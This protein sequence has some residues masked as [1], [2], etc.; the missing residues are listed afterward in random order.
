MPDP[1]T[2]VTDGRPRVAGPA[3]PV[4]VDDSAPA[5]AGPA[6]PVVV[7]TSGPVSAGAPLRVRAA[8]PGRPVAAGPALPVYVIAGSLGGGAPQLADPLFAQINTTVADDLSPD[9]MNWAAMHGAFL[10][11]SFGKYIQYEQ[12]YNANT[13]QCYFVFSNDAGAT[14]VDNAGIAGGEGFLVRGD[15]VYDAGRDCLHS[16]ICTTNPSDGGIIYRR[17]TISRDG[18]NNIT[19]IARVVGVSV[20]LDDAAANN[21][22]GLEFPTIRMLDANTLFAAWTIATVSPGGE[23]R[24]CRC[25]I[26]GNANAGGTAS[27]WVHL[28]VNST[29]TIGAAPA[30]GSY[31]IPFTQATANAPTYFS[32]LQ[33]AAGDIRFVYH[34]GASPGA[35]RTRR[36]V[37]SGASWTSL[38]SP[39]VV[40][41]V[42]RAGTDAGYSLKQQ[43]VS[44]LSEDAAGTV[45]VGLATWASNT[46]GDTWT[47]YSI[48]AADAIAGPTNVYSAGGAHSYAPTGDAAY[49]AT[50]DRV[51]ATYIISGAGVEYAYAGLY[52]PALVEAQAPFLVFGTAPVDIP[53]IVDVR[54]G[55]QVLMAFRD[56]VN[57]PTPPYTGWFGRLDWA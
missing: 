20:V 46:L 42:Q 44:Q 33:Q 55:N 23:I 1:V 29:T 50:A 54:E 12:R 43:L 14:W 8:G 16:L 2:V 10:I 37:K 47:L 22:N 35:W 13:R 17:Y 3:Q 18:S 57:T 9:G 7:V 56:T 51:V 27:N 48:S 41:N 6:Q 39:V 38:S 31:T 19:S 4:I 30:V 25:D 36:L 24:C 5:T 32:V 15:I 45:Y 53:L 28:G 49:D 34:T 26:S 40:T 52:T 11:D 21:S